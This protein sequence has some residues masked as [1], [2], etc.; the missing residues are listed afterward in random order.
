MRRL[1]HGR[2][3][4]G[5]L[6]GVLLWEAWLLFRAAMSTFAIDGEAFMRGLLAAG[7]VAVAGGIGIFA[8]R[9]HVNRISR[10]R[11]LL[12][13]ELID[14]MPFGVLLLSD[15]G[16]ITYANSA[17]PL[18]FHQ[19]AIGR[20]YLDLLRERIDAGEIYGSGQSADQTFERLS[21][22]VFL[23]GATTEVH[24]TDG[25]D[26]LRLTRRLPD[27]RFLILIRDITSDKS[28]LREIEALNVGL[29][30]QIASARS[31]NEDLRHLAYAASHDLR[32]P[33]NTALFLLSELEVE[34][35]N[36]LPGEA[37]D[38]MSD[39]RTTLRKMNAV[40]GDL[41]DY[42]EAMPDS[43]P[44]DE[45]C[46]DT[47]VR[48]SIALLRADVTEVNAKIEV[49]PLPK[50]PGNPAQ[51]GQLF[52]NL[53]SNAMKFRA[54]TRAPSIQIRQSEAPMRKGLIGIDVTDNGIGIES[55]FYGTIFNLFKRLH[56]EAEYPGTGIGLAACQ[57]IARAHGGSVSVAPAEPHGTTFTVW[58][59]SGPEAS[60]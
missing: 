19:N 60:A 40:A 31:A 33:T 5:L 14:R 50:V 56:T 21:S 26:L 17:A 32:A 20:P 22:D 13:Q 2:A 38:L 15:A 42:S 29:I 41:L 1:F 16:C 12:S 10:A 57:R 24:L 36:P 35:P 39:L 25:R 53:L 7:C 23:D 44:H 28:R 30:A 51:L 11:T 18:F 34:L 37:A 8:W 48:D 49:S 43:D 45:V 3:F 47:T 55:K 9:Q 54:S 4:F 6:I 27:G 59:P 46:L 58:L 52:Q